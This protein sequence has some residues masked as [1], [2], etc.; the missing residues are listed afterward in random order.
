MPNTKQLKAK[1]KTVKNLQK[2][3]SAMEVASTAKLQKIKSQTAFFKEYFY[4]F[5]HV[6]NYVQQHINLF[7]SEILQI[8]ENA[9]RL[10]VVIT[11]DKGLAGGINTNLLKR[12]VKGYGERKEKVDIIAI[13]KK[14]E[15]FFVRNGRNVVASLQLKDTIES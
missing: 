9:K 7:E 1:I 3:I 8:D 14:G 5:L 2:I 12:I 15:E 4:E 13:G 10:L 11:S 6:L